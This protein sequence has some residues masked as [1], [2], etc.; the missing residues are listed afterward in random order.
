MSETV[1]LLDEGWTV[2]PRVATYSRW[3]PVS[4]ENEGKK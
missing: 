1:P 3:V 2:E 4:P